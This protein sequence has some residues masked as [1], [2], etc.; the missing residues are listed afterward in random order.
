M[1]AI[2]A[3]LGETADPENHERM[4]RMIVRSPYRGEPEQQI[5]EG[6][7][8]ATM[9]L[10]WDA[11]LGS[12]RDW[13][14]ALQGYISNWD[15]IA[16]TFA[17]DFAPMRTSAEKI[18]CAYDRLGDSLF[19]KLRGEFAVLLYNRRSQC[20]R[21][22]TS[23]V[24]TRPLFFKQEKDRILFGTEIRQILAASGEK[25]VLNEAALVNVILNRAIPS[26]E[27][28][29]VGIS[30]ILPAKIHAFLQT[31]EVPPI[32]I[33]YW[34]PPG[35]IH[36]PQR[37]PDDYTEELTYHLKKA[38]QRTLPPVP[39][40]LALSG[41]LDSGAI[42]AFLQ[43]LAHEGNSRA[44]D[45]INI[46][47][48]HPG[49]E[50]DETE[51][52][53]ATLKNIGVTA[54][55]INGLYFAS[56]LFYE[57]FEALDLTTGPGIHDFKVITDQLRMNHR[58]VLL[59]G[60]GGDEWLEGD[61]HFLADEF[62]SF[63]FRSILHD[64]VP[65]WRG[66]SLSLPRFVWRNVIASKWTFPRWRK[67]PQPEW[68]GTSWRLPSHKRGEK[69]GEGHGQKVLP[70]GSIHTQRELQYAQLTDLHPQIE[71]FIARQGIEVRH[72]FMD[73]DLVEF[74]FRTPPRVL[75]GGRGGK[76]L[77][78]QALKGHLPPEVLN[79]P[80]I[81][82]DTLMARHAELTYIP[83]AANWFLVQRGIIDGNGLTQLIKVRHSD[84]ASEIRLF[85][86]WWFE[87][88][89]Q[90]FKCNQE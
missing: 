57:D 85:E 26:E 56:D 39:F 30:R 81:Y 86:L 11:S 44:P 16:T 47:L 7:I 49:F 25:P 20:L 58:K 52:I 66:S 48:I 89:C 35:A 73:L 42:L 18:A 5:A 83:P 75:L 82:W 40:G 70:R 28:V 15:D 62:R 41:G 59:T 71:Q 22:L 12:W 37:Q 46:S 4:E 79:G 45:N 34:E 31:Q 14:V 24:G 61:L 10:G 64:F 90:R 36:D 33:S 55:L 69:E 32:Q 60:V 50:C 2:L 17:L 77:M 76:G 80:N 8:V 74:G 65:L 72:P 9:S 19:S 63:H 1:G 84:S 21:A 68:L 38:V 27:T 53:H 23:P 13:L 51:R 3:I 87:N 67:G 6:L 29:Y 78:R 43:E 88:F 54:E